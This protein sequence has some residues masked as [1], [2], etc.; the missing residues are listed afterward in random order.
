MSEIVKREKARR[1][2]RLNKKEGIPVLEALDTV[3]IS[4]DVYYRIKDEREEEWEEEILTVE[5]IQKRLSEVEEELERKENKLEQMEDRVQ[6]AQQ[7]AGQLATNA[8]LL[9]T[10]WSLEEKVEWMEEDVERLCADAGFQTQSGLTVE[11]VYRQVKDLKQQNLAGRVGDLERKAKNNQ[12]RSERNARKIGVLKED[13][14][15]SVFDL[16]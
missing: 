16:L 13:I 11:G 2:W 9:D 12:R 15:T 10:V 5:Q 6:K 8:G 4:K 1:V 3:D 7:A 14:P